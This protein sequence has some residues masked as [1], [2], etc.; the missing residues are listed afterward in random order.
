MVSCK[1]D[2]LAAKERKRVPIRCQKIK[3][4]IDHLQRLGHP[5]D[6]HPK[7]ADICFIPEIKDIILTAEKE[8][9]KLFVKQTLPETYATLSQDCLEKREEILADLITKSQH[10]VLPKTTNL[11]EVGSS[12]TASANRKLLDLATSWFFCCRVMDW[13]EAHDHSCIYVP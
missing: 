13:R 10:P 1:I 3:D 11:R 5:H 9:F 12:A 8:D 2:R 6:L 7:P 4:A